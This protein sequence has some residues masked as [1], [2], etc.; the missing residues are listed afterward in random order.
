MKL[1]FSILLSFF[2]CMSLMT[3][4]SQYLSADDSD[5]EAIDLLTEAGKSFST[6][7]SQVEFTLEVSYPGQPSMVSQGTLYQS[8]E[9]YHLDLKE[10]A[11]FSDGTTRWIYLKGPNEINVY[12][13]SN[14]QDWISPQ[15]FLKL[16]TSDELVLSLIG[17]RG[18][19]VTVVAAKPLEGRFDQYSK[20]SVGIKDG[21]LKYINAISSDGSKQ[22]MSIT[23]ISHPDHLDTKKLFTFDKAS[24]PGVY[25]EDLRLD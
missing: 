24:Y 5:Q 19:G 25:V 10:Y 20:F 16:H 22:E 9:A 15:D 8:G 23:K 2:L 14:G 3:A 12:N 6:R 17:T 13:E 11:I 1:T 18:D 21:S 4:Q 7:P